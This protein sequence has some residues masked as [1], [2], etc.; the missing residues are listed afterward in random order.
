MLGARRTVGLELLTADI[1]RVKASQYCLLL[2]TRCGMAGAKYKLI[3]VLPC[4]IFTSYD[5]LAPLFVPRIIPQILMKNLISFHVLALN[6]SEHKFSYGN[7]NDV[8]FPRAIV[9]R[10]HHRVSARIR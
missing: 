6:E 8:S 1:W 7:E 4:F 10:N 9:A 5:S 3:S 2:G